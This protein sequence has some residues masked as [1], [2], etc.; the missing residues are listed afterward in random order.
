M[1]QHLQMKNM[2]RNFDI[3]NLITIGENLTT[4]N[5]DLSESNG[6]CER[7]VELDEDEEPS[8]NVNID[9]SIKSLDR[10]LF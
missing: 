1:Q 5:T 3:N 9:T 2:A 8:T 6:Q 10:A 7:K 4:E